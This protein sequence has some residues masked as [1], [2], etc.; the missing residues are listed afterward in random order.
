MIRS[1]ELVG[2]NSIPDGYGAHFE[3][4]GAPWWLRVWF[5][6]PFIERFAYP[7]VVRRGFGVLSRMPG[8]ADEQL[9][10]VVGGW[11]IE[12]FDSPTPRSDVGLR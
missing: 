4:K 9:G 12:P 2:W 3:L 10:A 11:R 6:I 1:V 8:Y 7:V 5:R